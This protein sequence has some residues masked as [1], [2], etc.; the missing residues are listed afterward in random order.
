M[1]VRDL[2]IQ[3]S[4]LLER[5]VDQVAFGSLLHLIRDSFARGHTDRAQPAPGERC[6]LANDSVPAPG[7]V[8]EFHSY[9]LQ[10]HDAHAHEDSREAKDRHLQNNPNVVA[11]GRPL[12][13]GVRSA[14]TLE[15]SSALSGLLVPTQRRDVRIGPGR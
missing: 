10:D 1:G 11:L 4:P 13:R 5:R 15:R 3:G 12:V 6:T 7:R 14:K 2:F 9:S 8:N